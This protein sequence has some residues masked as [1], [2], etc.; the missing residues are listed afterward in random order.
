LRAKGI[1]I[2][3]HLYY[4]VK[5]NLLGKQARKKQAGKMVAKVAETTGTGNGDAVSTI[6]KVKSLANQV[7]GLKRLRALVEALS[8]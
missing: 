5:G 7:G 3:D 4:F 8:E 6:L 2:S 1:K